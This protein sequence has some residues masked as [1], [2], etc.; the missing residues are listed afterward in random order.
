M[1]IE[2]AMS[3]EEFQKKS[4]K[5]TGNN[6]YEHQ[7]QVMIFDWAKI[8]V[9][10][11]PQLDM[12]Y[13][14]PNGGV[15]GWQTA[16]K[17]KAEGTKSGVPDMCLPVVIGGFHGLYIELKYGKNILSDSQRW[18][19]KKLQEQ[20]YCVDVCYGA[21]EAIKLIESYLNGEEI[22]DKKF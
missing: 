9:H 5:E 10:K 19:L 15:R 22:D 14:V 3:M 18:W 17:L 4:K 1:I 6:D 20:G 13:A 16:V 7:E 12:L 11:Y 21:N 8:M 2:N